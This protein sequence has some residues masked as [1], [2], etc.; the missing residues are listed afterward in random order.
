M[1]TKEHT[2]TI[3]RIAPT[4]TGYLHKGNAFNFIYTNHLVRQQNGKLI[5]RIDDLDKVRTKD[6]FIDD[7]FETLSW[8]GITCDEGPKDRTDFWENYSQAKRSK[9]YEA[10]ALSLYE[11]KQAYA[12]TCSRTQIQKQNPFGHYPG[13]CRTKNIP[14]ILGENA[15]RLNVEFHDNDLFDFV[16]WRRDNIPAYNLVSL[17]DDITM[18]VNLI[19]RGEDLDIATKNQKALAQACG[20]Q[21][22]LDCEFVHH[23]LL[24]GDDH[25]KLSKSLEATSI[26]QL[27]QEGLK[28]RDLYQEASDF[29]GL[30]LTF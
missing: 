17:V 26:K 19:V 16:I 7:I 11:K 6:E 27:R 12:C 1:H 2:Q 28:V 21:E 22:F 18:G 25:E 15:L 14:F 30:N 3:S 13:F 10:V 4:P 9:I 23:P 24:T 20:Y 5:L 29:F 8:L